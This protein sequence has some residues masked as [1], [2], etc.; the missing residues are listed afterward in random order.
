MVY[1]A[2]FGDIIYT[3]NNQSPIINFGCKVVL[4]V[5][6]IVLFCF[7]KGNSM[8]YWMNY[9]LLIA[10]I[11]LERHSMFVYKKNVII[12]ASEYKRQSEK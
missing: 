10:Y 12:K 7:A 4:R 11:L 5:H 1:E 9:I 2:N 3:G 6:D 8:Y